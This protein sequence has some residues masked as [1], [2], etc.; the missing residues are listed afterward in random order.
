MSR[1]RAFKWLAAILVVGNGAWAAAT[2]SILLEEGGHRL[3]VRIETEIG[4]AYDLEMSTNLVS[5]ETAGL[6]QPGTGAEIGIEMP[7]PRSEALFLRVRER[8]FAQTVWFV[9]TAGNNENAGTQPGSPLR[10]IQAAADRMQAGDVCYIREGVYRETVVVPVLAG[11]GPQPER[12]FRA[13]PGE[14]VGIRGDDPLDDAAWEPHAGSIHRR[15]GLEPVTEVYANGRMLWMARWPNAPSPDPLEPAWSYM[16]AVPGNYY[17]KGTFTPKLYDHA[18]EQP[19]GTW[20]GARIFFTGVERWWSRSGDI[21]QHG[22]DPGEIHI[23]LYDHLQDLWSGVMPAINAPFFIYNA[24]AALDAPG[25]WYQDPDGTLYL[26]APG[27]GLPENI[28]VKRRDVL[29]DL[30]GCRNVRI[31]NLTF[32]SGRVLLHDAMDCVVA[33]NRFRYLSPFFFIRFPTWR[34]R[35][36]FHLSRISNGSGIQTSGSATG[37]VIE[38]N[39]IAFSWGDGITLGGTANTARGNHIRDVN[40]IGSKMAGVFLAGSDN[41]VRGN[42]I[43]RTGRSGIAVHGTG[44]RI[45]D[46]HIYDCG[47]INW[48][49]GGIY[50]Y[51]GFN[52]FNGYGLEIAGNRIHDIQLDNNIGPLGA[53]FGGSGIYL[54]GGASDIDVHHNILYRLRRYGI[55]LNGDGYFNRDNENVRIVNNT[56]I[57]DPASSLS[58][59]TGGITH[60]SRSNVLIANN[61]YFDEAG[62]A[63]G[64]T[65]VNNIRV[66]ASAFVDFEAYDFRPAAGSALID[67][68]IEVPPLT[69][70]FHGPAPDAGA[71]ESETDP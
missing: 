63:P 43:H 41:V 66:G 38:N 59:L 28:S 6:S 50:L 67:A 12:V 19:V 69:D 27:G 7:L 46:N 68:G 71:L 53:Q 11:S 35:A 32:F 33:G 14:R 8:P 40:Y 15:D 34:D 22:P 10:N 5:W 60:E 29:F 61:A 24:Y 62:S 54:D 45:R 23:Q 39:D 9:S 37:N 13:Y 52:A 58:K 56:V 49:L 70:G 44:G 1:F 20:T 64:A 4:T 26:I 25:E 36:E 31:E 48:D 55:Q 57:D 21:L 51:A 42:T 16:D 17:Q 2:P 65:F 3:M 47:R 30:T 18:I